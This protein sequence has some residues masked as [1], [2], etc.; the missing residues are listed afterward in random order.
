MKWNNLIENIMIKNKG[1]ASLNLLYSEAGKYKDLPSG[2]WQKTLR[3]VLCREVNRGRFKKIGLGVYALSNYKKDVNSAY[4]FALKNVPV[5]EYIKNI[6]DCHST[7][8][9][10]LIET[11]NFF[12][13]TTFTC[14]LNKKFDGK[15]LKELCGITNIPNFTYPKLIKLISKSDVV[16]FAETTKLLFPK[17][18]F[19]VELT[20][21]F[22]SSL[23]K[24]Y[25][26]LNF[27]A[28]FIL[29]A[30]EKRKTK[31]EDTI[32]RDPF[33]KEQNRFLFRSFEDVVK[34]YFTTVI[35]Y[36]LRTKFII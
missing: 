7:I 13:Y 25:Q 33:Y 35:H 18:I 22:T 11:G 2:D 1:L 34:L 23:L 9:G 15:K 19:E 30:P 3:K 5:D 14:D 6:R 10:M 12:G 8:E 4:S 20:T 27:D 28:K 24:M 36:E 26:L 31:F 29:V 32:N 21:N 16:W 17:S